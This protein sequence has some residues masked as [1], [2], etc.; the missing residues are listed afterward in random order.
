[1]KWFHISR[2]AKPAI[3]KLLLA[4][5]C[6]FSF[7]TLSL[8]HQISVGSAYNYCHKALQELPT[9]I[10]VTRDFGQKYQGVLLVDGKYIQVKPYDRKIPVLYGV[11]YQTHDIPH[12]RLSRAE[13]Y[14]TCKKFFESLK[15][16]NYVLQAVVCDDNKNIYQAARYVYPQVVVQLCHIHFLRNMRALLNPET[17][18]THREFFRVLNAL[19]IAKR[20]R[21]DFERRAARLVTEFSQDDVCSAILIELARK[22]PL[23]QGYMHHRGTPTTTNLIESFNSHLEARVRP[24]KGFES[25]KYADLWLNGYFLKRRTTKFTDCTKKFNR[26]NG[27]TSLEVV[28]KPGID[29][30]LFF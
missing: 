6:G 17:I 16:T 29:I 15:L 18:P 1:L 5:L 11:D 13:N 8:H 12:Y 21:D 3:Q 20:S 10:D 7:R 19:L 28:K 24:L 2:V 26:L 30:P 4:H 22:Q 9:C 27:K 23:L 25:F 14:L